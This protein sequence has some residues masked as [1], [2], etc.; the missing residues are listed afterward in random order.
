MD[1]LVRKKLL[2]RIKEL[3]EANKKVEE[4]QWLEPGFDHQN[5]FILSELRRFMVLGNRRSG[6]TEGVVI[7]G[8]YE[9]YSKQKDA[10]FF[11]LTRQSVK[12]VIWPKI[13]KFLKKK[14][15]K[16]VPSLGEL[17]ISFPGR[18]GKLYLLGL[19][20]GPDEA[21]KI[22]GMNPCFVAIDEAASYT[23]DL[24]RIID[25]VIWPALRDYNGKIVLCGTPRLPSRGIFFE[26]TKPNSDY[27][28]R[29]EWNIRFFDALNNPFMRSQTL[30]ER[31]DIEK[32]R[33]EFKNTPAYKMMELGEWALDDSL[34]VYRC[35]LDNYI[36]Q[37]PN[38]KKLDDVTFV[39]GI[40]L[41]LKDASS[42][43]VCAFSKFDRTLYVVESLKMSYQDFTDVATKVKYFNRKY[44]IGINI[45]D[46]A[47]AQGIAEINNRHNLALI[48]AE[49][50][51]KKTYIDLIN[52]DF[53][54]KNIK[55]CHAENL[56]LI[57]ELNTL[58][59]NEKLIKDKKVWKEKDSLPNHLCD[60][61]LYAW[62]FS[63]HF[64]SDPMK[65]PSNYDKIMTEEDLINEKMKN[66]YI[67]QLEEEQNNN[68]WW[69]V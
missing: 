34:I 18:E 63:Y 11:G 39:L 17:S 4:I 16:F 32:N 65:M 53:L 28:R 66:D 55:I 46:G 56:D 36:Y 42:F 41:G 40:D 7:K 69:D 43:V 31:E 22:L 27:K 10:V 44:R 57:D 33:P 30:K 51:D 25:E 48:P 62:R 12:R 26:V 54:T 15:I 14:K 8:L 47:N 58:S 45:C 29:N 6:K 59:W 68:H 60:A 37:I 49:K 23:Q 20:D 64:L 1:E 2:E 21:E 50:I 3:D 24:E 38:F 13:L 67:Q 35:S 61:L 5:E 9:V 19:N 52:S